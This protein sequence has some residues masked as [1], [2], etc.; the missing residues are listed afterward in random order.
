MT[1]QSM[2]PGFD[3]SQAGENDFTPTP[4]WVTRLLLEVVPPPPGPVIEPCAG[5]GDIVRVL[6]EAGWS[7]DEIHATELRAAERPRL[8]QYGVNVEIGD[9]SEIRH[10][11]PWPALNLITNPPFG[12]LP[13]FAE[14]CFPPFG[15]G[16]DYVA[17]LMPI[18]EAAG[19]QSTGRAL[20][21]LGPP[22]DWILIS[23]RIWS[24]VRGCAWYI[25][26][27][28]Q[29]LQRPGLTRVHIA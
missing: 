16:M 1:G 20:R 26:R 27:R 11:S 6:I 22:T 25:W 7:P 5:S 2:L 9:W 17:L 28:D 24:K 15:L 3:P 29:Q 23:R 12:M 10:R 14:W 19:K 13:D 4:G 8:E 21:R 18:D